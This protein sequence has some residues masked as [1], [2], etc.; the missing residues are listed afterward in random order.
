M[1]GDGGAEGGAEPPAPDAYLSAASDHF[2]LLC[3]CHCTEASKSMGHRLVTSLDSLPDWWD[4]VGG[5]GDLL[6]SSGRYPSPCHIAVAAATTLNLIC[7]F[8]DHGNT[9]VLC[10]LVIWNNES[11]LG[12][13]QERDGSVTTLMNPDE[14]GH[15]QSVVMRGS[16]FAA[17][18]ETV[19]LEKKQ[20]VPESPL[21]AKS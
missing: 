9:M 10:T 21:T 15:Q 19:D 20:A 8:E 13:F 4:A 6:D 5:V 1:K 11:T 2:E 3:R 7:H 17:M 14:K 16:F 12:C 18:A